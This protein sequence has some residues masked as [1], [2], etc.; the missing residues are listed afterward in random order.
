MGALTITSWVAVYFGFFYVLGAIYVIR[1]RVQFLVAIGDGG[2]ALLQKAIRAH[3]NL[4]EYVPMAII[5]LILCELKSANYDVIRVAALLLCIGRMV[6]FYG[7]SRPKEK[8]IFR[9]TGMFMTFGSLILL[10]SALL[11]VLVGG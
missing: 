4:V 10:S 6:H 5:L 3:G 7:V 1:R 8:L 9:Q 11:W 2:Q